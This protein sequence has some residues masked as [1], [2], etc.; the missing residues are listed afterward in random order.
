MR[1]VCGFV[2]PAHRDRSIYLLRVQKI[3]RG[4]KKNTKPQNAVS[5][6]GKSGE[7]Q[8]WQSRGASAAATGVRLGL[9]AAAFSPDRVLQ[10]IS[11][12]LHSQH[13]HARAETALMLTGDNAP[14]RAARAAHGCVSARS[15]MRPPPAVGRLGFTALPGAPGIGTAAMA[16]FHGGGSRPAV[17]PQDPL[18]AVPTAAMPT[19][20]WRCTSRASQL[21]AEPRGGTSPESPWCFP[22]PR[23]SKSIFSSSPRVTPRGPASP[24]ASILALQH[25]KSLGI[26]WRPGIRHPPGPRNPAGE[27][28]LRD[29]IGI[30]AMP[31]SLS[32][33]ARPATCGGS[34][35]L[36]AQHARTRVS[37]LAPVY[38]PVLRLERQRKRHRGHGSARLGG[39]GKHIARLRASAA[40][41]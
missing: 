6:T 39:S 21:P 25:P 36:P 3:K 9:L 38:S 35:R 26:D 12:K 7:R 40:G 11:P 22:T 5:S 14:G 31:G 4:G 37:A 33:C 10:G 8:R 41:G 27:I 30:W 15:P 24:A 13:W 34:I 16:S 19:G 1:A 32:E 23:Q 17:S 29:F 20:V 2:C 18:P 28:R